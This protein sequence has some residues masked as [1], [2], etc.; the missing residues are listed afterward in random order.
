MSERDLAHHNR[1]VVRHVRRRVLAAVLQL[2]LH[3]A[4]ELLHGE[5]PLACDDRSRTQHAKESPLARQATVTTSRK[6]LSGP[7][8]LTSMPLPFISTVLVPSR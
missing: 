3:A 6:W 7:T 5:R 4:P 2:D 8:V 1:V